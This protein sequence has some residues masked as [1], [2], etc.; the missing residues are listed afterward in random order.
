MSRVTEFDGAG[1]V[2]ER[3]VTYTSVS[4]PDQ[5][6]DR[7][8][9]SVSNTTTY[10]KDGQQ[11]GSTTTVTKRVVDKDGK[12]KSEQTR[13][14]VYDKDGK[15]VSDT[16]RPAPD[17]GGGSDTDPRLQLLQ[18]SRAQAKAGLRL[19]LVGTPHSD[20]DHPEEPIPPAQRIRKRLGK[21]I[22]AAAGPRGDSTDYGHEGGPVL[23]WDRP[24]W[25]MVVSVGR[26]DSDDYDTKSPRERTG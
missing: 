23:P 17:D 25:G 15:V 12:T 18:F 24:G 13:T 1:H 19:L 10:D 2:T 8:E 6:G 4:K 26:H 21:A 5:N 9:Q 7:V 22:A 20:D 11:T 14:V 16:G 3:T